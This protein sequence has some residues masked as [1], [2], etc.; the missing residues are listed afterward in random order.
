MLLE[1]FPTFR[2]TSRCGAQHP[3]FPKGRK[4]A[5][6][7]P[8]DAAQR[9]EECKTDTINCDISSPLVFRFPV[10]KERKKR[11]NRT[12]T[13]IDSYWSCTTDFSEIFREAADKLYDVYFPDSG[14]VYTRWSC[15]KENVLDRSGRPWFGRQAEFKGCGNLVFWFIFVPYRRI[16]KKPTTRHDELRRSSNNTK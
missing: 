9:W 4:I 12:L 13:H 6:H 7:P 1:I 14:C 15:W 8:K 5:F 10:G 11:L 16:V 2:Y 3:A